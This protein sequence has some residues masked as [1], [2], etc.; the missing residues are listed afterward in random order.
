MA[1]FRQFVRKP[2]TGW[3]KKS[4]MQGARKIDERRRTWAVRWSEAIERN[5][6]DGLFSAAWV[7]LTFGWLSPNLDL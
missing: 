2:L 5:E 1:L 3:S 6:A 7:T 4:Q